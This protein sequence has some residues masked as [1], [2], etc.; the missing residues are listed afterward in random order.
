MVGWSTWIGL[1]EAVIPPPMELEMEAPRVRDMSGEG[2]K[3]WCTWCDVVVCG[4]HGG[5]WF[6]RGCLYR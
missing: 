5:V 4:V 3:M 2:C 6:G 1:A